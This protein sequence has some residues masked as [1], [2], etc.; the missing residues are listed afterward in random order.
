MPNISVCMATYNG[1]RFIR[2]QLESILTQLSQNDEVVISDDSSTDN[3]ISI[4][5]S[6]SDPRIRLYESNTFYN[7]IFNFENAL[8]NSNGEIVVLSDQD[9]VWLE[10]KINVIRDAFSNKHDCIY[11]LVM[12]GFVVDE[13]EVVV[14]DSIFKCI[15]AGKGLVKN[16][17]DNTFLGCNIAFSKK[18][19]T[20][21]LPFP[22]KIPM[23][24]M[25]LG[26]LGEIFGEV[27]FVAQK[28]IKYRKHSN[29]LTEFRRRFIPV[30]QLKRRWFLSCNLISRWISVRCSCNWS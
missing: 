18:L 10:N 8:K 7:P 23:H 4:I 16:I 21:A 29:S 3:T 17:Y 25:W 15:G 22:D 14:F 24:D 2:R 6:F 5:K 13:N 9:D 11:L 20:I 26:L 28:T 19:L 1:E 30:T 27:D 12:D